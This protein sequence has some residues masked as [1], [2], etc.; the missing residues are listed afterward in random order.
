[1][2]TLI[3]N[4]VQYSG[5]M[6]AFLQCF[7]NTTGYTTGLSYAL[8]QL[9]FVLQADTYTAQWAAAAAIGNQALPISAG[10]LTPNSGSAAIPEYGS[11]Y[12]SAIS[13]AHF[14]GAYNGATTYNL[15]DVV[16]FTVNS[17]PLVYICVHASTSGQAPMSYSAGAY[18]LN[19]T[20]WSPYYMEVWKFGTSGVYFKVEYGTSTTASQPTYCVQM[21]YTYST[22]SSGYLSGQT[23]N[24]MSSNTSSSSAVTLYTNYFTSDGQSY[25]GII[26]WYGSSYCNLFCT[27]LQI[28]GATSSAPVYGTAYW[29]AF[30]GN[31]TPYTQFFPASGS[32]PTPQQ[33]VLGIFFNEQSATQLFQGQSALFPIFPQGGGYMGNPMTVAATVNAED[34]ASNS[35]L[36]GLVY[37]SNHNY[38]I[39]GGAPFSDWFSSGGPS[40]AIRWE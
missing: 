11:G 21:G 39:L 5:T 13:S 23:S 18:T 37:G 20:Y 19:S 16:T 2:A 7:G 22:G 9:G 30:Y 8:Q 40:G 29:N 33:G 14:K 4:C 35:V 27:E 28:T 17:Q 32:V 26:M 36:Q 38:L 31:D 6:I 34:W 12:R 3:T 15:G 25:L 24:V 1:M 10:S